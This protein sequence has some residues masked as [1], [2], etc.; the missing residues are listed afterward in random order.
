MFVMLAV[1]MIM[2]TTAVIHPTK[3]ENRH[4]PQPPLLVP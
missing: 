4:Q 3:D 2:K 1:L